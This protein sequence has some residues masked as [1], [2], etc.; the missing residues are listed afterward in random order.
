[1]RLSAAELRTRGNQVWYPQFPK[2]ETPDPVEWKDLIEQESKMMDE[3][4]VGEKIAIAHSLGCLNW[5][6]A[7][8]SSRLGQPFDRVIFVAPPD[9]IRT[10]E[11][12]GIEGKPMD[13]KN[14]LL[15]PG[16]KNFTKTFEIVASD[17]DHWLPRGI[18]IYEE[19]L[20]QQAV[21][22]PGAGHFSLADGWGEWPGLWS[23]VASGNQEDLI[24]R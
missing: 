11:A 18:G 17:K 16:I 3:V 9:P 20:K 15:L 7:A 22:I 12:E 21:V 6:V 23:W 1:M 5:M 24:T 2:P 13:L 19:V 8:M 10:E 14:P 4:Q